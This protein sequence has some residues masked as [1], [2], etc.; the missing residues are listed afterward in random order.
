MLERMFCEALAA[1][2]SLTTTEVARFHRMERDSFSPRPGSLKKKKLI[3]Q[4]GYRLVPNAAGKITKMIA[5]RPRL[6]TDT[7]PDMTPFDQRRVTAKMLKARIHK[8][9]E[10]LRAILRQPWTAGPAMQSIAR[11]TLEQDK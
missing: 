3:V 1:R 11:Y 7:S 5:F 9:E 6:E 8:L 10:A 4:D 2:G